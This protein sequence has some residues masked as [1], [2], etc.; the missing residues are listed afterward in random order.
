MIRIGLYEVAYA[1][2]GDRAMVDSLKDR[3]PLYGD[4]DAE[5]EAENDG[6]GVAPHPPKRRD[7]G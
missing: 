4:K 2:R 6:N 1:L 3:K 7:Q 5:A